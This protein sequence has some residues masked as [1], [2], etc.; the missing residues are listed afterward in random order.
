M[1]VIRKDEEA[2]PTSSKQMIPKTRKQL[3][4]KWQ[5]WQRL[6]NTSMGSFNWQ[7]SGKA[8]R[9][10]TQCGSATGGW[11]GGVEHVWLV[12][13]EEVGDACWQLSSRLDRELSQ[14][15]WTESVLGLAGS[16]WWILSKQWEWS[17][18]KMANIGSITVLSRDW[19]GLK[20]GYD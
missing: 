9:H 11:V 12:C 10:R 6:R 14:L 4:K 7:N 1:N 19:W 3:E 17:S 8:P 13:T 15:L 16:C 2:Q 20:Q 18:R 5:I